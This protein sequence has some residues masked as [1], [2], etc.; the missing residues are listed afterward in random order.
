MTR[1]VVGVEAK[2][3][4]AAKY[5]GHDWWRNEILYYAI[6]DEIRAEERERNRVEFWAWKRAER[7]AAKAAGAAGAEGAAEAEEA[8]EEASP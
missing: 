7:A 3:R 8:E 2:R 1:S 4:F 6:A 5:P